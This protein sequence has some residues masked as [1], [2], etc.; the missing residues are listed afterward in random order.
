MQATRR[1]LQATQ[2]PELAS[3]A[4]NG[5]VHVS[6]R[7]VLNKKDFCEYHDRGVRLPPK[8]PWMSYGDRAKTTVKSPAGSRARNIVI[9]VPSTAL[10]TDVLRALKEARV[11]G[12]EF[13]LSRREYLNGMRKAGCHGSAGKNGPKIAYTP[14]MLSPTHVHSNSSHS[15]S[16]R[17]RAQ[18]RPHG[19]VPHLGQG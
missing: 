3:L 2:R 18:C 6:N 8:L 14:L 7:S 4:R 1:L 16:C 9:E 13:P 10:P 15:A 11:V 17:Q 19:A 12:P 5:G